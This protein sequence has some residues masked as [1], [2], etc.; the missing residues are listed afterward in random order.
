ME[1]STSKINGT[2]TVLN[3]DLFYSQLREQ[4]SPT[5]KKA[6]V[7]ILN[8]F[9][10]A[11]S[12]QGT[13][14]FII[15][16]NIPRLDKSWYRIEK[17]D[18]RIYVKN[19]IIAVSI[20]D[21]YN[22]ADK[23]T[24]ENESDFKDDHLDFQD[25][26]SKMKW[27]LTNYLAS[28]CMMTR[29]YITIHPLVWVRNSN[30]VIAKKNMV[31]ASELT[32][33]LIEKAIE[34]NSYFK[35]AGYK[36]WYN[37]EILFEHH[38]R[39]IFERASLDSQEGYITK[40]KIDRFNNK[41][42]DA[43]NK[44]YE[45]IGERLVEV[46]GKAGTGKSSDILKW[47][48][49]KSL[50][51]QSGVYLTYNHLLVYDITAQIQSFKNRHLR[52]G[53]KSPKPTTAFTIHKFFYNIANKLGVLLMLTESRIE[54]LT[55]ILDSRGK[56]IENYFNTIRLQENEISLAKLLMIVQSKWTAD[57]GTKRE[58]I[59][60]LQFLKSEKFLPD[61]VKT[62]Q[63][64][65]LFR[66][67]K[68]KK[69]ASF[70]SSNVFLK[71]YNKVLERIFE[72]TEDLD[73]F[74][75]EQDVVNKF[76]L[77]AWKLGLDTNVLEKDGSGKI[78]YKK[79]KSRYRRS[80]SAFAS[81]RILYVDEGQDCH[82]RERDIL[83][84]LFGSQNIVIAN[85]EK[86]QLIRYSQLCNWN[87][88]QNIK[89]DLHK[90]SKRR[91]SYRMKPAI[92]ALSNHIAA[93]YEINLN[94]EPLETPDHGSIVLD[95]SISNT[96]SLQTLKNFKLMGERQGCTAYESILLLSHSNNKLIGDTD[97]PKDTTIKVNEFN[98]IIGSKQ[99]VKKEFEFIHEANAEINDVRFWESTGNVDKRELSVP[100]ALSIRSIYYESC[101]GIEAWSVMCFNLDDFFEQKSNEKDAD[102]YM[103]SNILLTP[104]QR[105][106][107]YAATWV[108]MAITRCIENCYKQIKD[109]SSSIFQCIAEFKEKNPQC[110]S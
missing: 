72:A 13:I 81:K 12:S 94:I 26:L 93:W 59:L 61:L 43:S 44:A 20:V 89:I 6:E 14:D 64:F 15:L 28:N 1:L 99:S 92:A 71:D 70:E 54:E 79:L 62:A 109:P 36:D 31:F 29:Q 66:D 86:E 83:Y 104:E 49:K 56:E 50:E 40:R 102:N 27:G 37:S 58:A 78:N 10:V 105:R 51:G 17:D 63:L 11:V 46:S 32:Y 67:E 30:K 110:V 24:T 57:E 9:P 98:N 97:I 2:N 87:V 53:E 106:E 47:M 21:D 22:N 88:S 100:G 90:Y 5:C 18:E 48:L 95:T 16:L 41:L 80:L 108:L 52:N 76:E 19:Q 85:G 68:V 42:N 4:L 34:K 103:L 45:N 96:N 60:F 82:P 3:Y 73:K 23:K 25:S 69:L 77:L 101:R 35:W 33:D 91:K 8:N 38:I 84:N 39:T 75:E 74:L 7:I 55:Q 65:Q 107:M